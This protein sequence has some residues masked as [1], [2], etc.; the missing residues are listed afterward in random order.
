MFC[1]GCGLRVASPAEAPST[2]RP[3]T[4]D[5]LAEKVRAARPALEGERKQVTVLFADVKG[6]MDLQEDLDAEEW[7]EV[8]DRFMRILSDGVHRFEGTVDKF[9]GDGVMALFGAPVAHEDHARRACYAALH[10]AETIADYTDEL[11]RAKGLSFHARLGLNSGEVVVGA[12]GDDSHMEYTAVGHTVGLASRM[13]A[14]AE[15]GRAYLTEHTARL[16]SSYFRLADLGTFS[17]KGVREP[18]GVF[19]LE[20]VGALRSAYEV[21]RSRGLSRLVGRDDEAAALEGALV[22]AGAG[23][24][25]VLGVVGEPG[26]GNSHA[27]QR[28]GWRDTL[29][30]KRR[31]QATVRLLDEVP[32]SDDTLELRVT[33]RA[34]L[35]RIAFRQGGD[36]AESQ[37]LGDE[38][39]RLA[40]AAG[41][42]YG[43]AHAM[44]AK[45]F[46]VFGLGDPERALDLIG[47]GARLFE[48]IGEPEWVAVQALLAR[49][50]R[51]EEAIRIA[52]RAVTTG[53]EMSLLEVVVWALPVH[54]QVAYLTGDRRGGV[55]RAREAVVAAAELGNPFHHVF[56]GGGLGL[57]HVAAGQGAQAIEPLTIALDLARAQHVGLIEESNL[58]AYRAE[59]WL[60]TGEHAAALRDAEEA[61]AVAQRQRAR[62]YEIQ[63]LLSRARARQ[64]VA[65][66]ARDL[67]LADLAG[68]DT[69]I[70]ETGAHAWTAPVA[71]ERAR[72][73]D[74]T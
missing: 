17:V 13:E 64:V 69:A 3:V 36:P 29:E 68:A 31:W 71:E 53:R 63:A 19:A 60:Q 6:S 14:L 73:E 48:E 61:V 39:Q 43:Q 35:V 42:R 5:H 18:V 54:A 25:Q 49:V 47:G 51:F 12:I 1:S 67:V 33:A 52:D 46:L 74:S 70:E 57:A 44:G 62:V 15:P 65:P 28:A 10:L 24:G 30:A 41:D 37:G 66:V 11:R 16:V 27:A 38:A 9:T 59:A 20:G 23:T 45:G 8:M 55:G 26:V 2:V 40:E 21:A 34:R 72:A 22:K 7:H 32:E 56:A 50:G 58:L 4:P